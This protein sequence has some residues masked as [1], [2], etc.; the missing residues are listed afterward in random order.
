MK[1]PKHLGKIS[2]TEKGFP[3]I[4]FKDYYG[5]E[6]SVEMS[7]LALYEQPGSS[8]LWIGPDKKR[9]HMERDQVISLVMVLDSWL[10]TGE[11]LNS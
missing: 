4:I 7:T 8:A 1:K 5:M 10:Q 2:A 11:F 3:I 9:M 6:C